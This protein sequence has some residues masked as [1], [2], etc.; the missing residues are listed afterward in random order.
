MTTHYPAIP[1]P[2]GLPAFD[3]RI[4]SPLLQRGIARLAEITE[5]S[6]DPLEL[7][8]TFKPETMSG[9]EVMQM[10]GEV[11]L[12]GASLGIFA[13]DNFSGEIRWSI[14]PLEDQIFAGDDCFHVAD[15]I[16]AA[17]TAGVLAAFDATSGKEL[18]SFDRYKSEVLTDVQL[19][20]DLIGFA[21][22]LWYSPTGVL[23][24]KGIATI[25]SWICQ[26][27]ERRVTT[28][29]RTS[30]RPYLI[31]SPISLTITRG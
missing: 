10:V 18:W 7:R 22:G 12:I 23:H 26:R 3:Y 9:I 13:L 2:D 1:T 5:A 6:D 30:A 14:D 31:V 27:A 25:T 20:D 29:A 16:I 24:D 11:M 21:T 17:R 19:H 8:W 15:G 4:P 28:G